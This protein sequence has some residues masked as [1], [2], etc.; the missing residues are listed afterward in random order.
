MGILLQII[1]QRKLIN[2]RTNETNNKYLK[3]E[4]VKQFKNAG[5]SYVTIQF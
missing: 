5:L 2:Q 1:L 4:N 3:I